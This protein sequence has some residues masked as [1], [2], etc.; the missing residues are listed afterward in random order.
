MTK[1]E[2]VRQAV[3]TAVSL[4]NP[5]WTER[6]EELVTVARMT[7]DDRYSFVVGGMA[8]DYGCA[9]FTEGGGLLV[10]FHDDDAECLLCGWSFDADGE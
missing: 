6:D 8:S 2:E 9:A 4:D 1:A 5:D 10:S 7:A 3:I